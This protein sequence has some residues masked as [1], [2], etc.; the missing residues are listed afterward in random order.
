MTQEFKI[1][2]QPLFKVAW[3][4]S[5]VMLILIPIQ[6]LIF[7]I[8]PPP[9]TVIGLFELYHQSPFLGL[10]S[11]DFLYLINNIIL[12]VIFLTLFILLY[13]EKPTN[14][15]LALTFGLIGIACY[16]PSNP[17]FEM[18]TLSKLYFQ[19]QP[20]EVIRYLS[21]GEAL[22]AGYTGTAFDVYYVLSGMAIILFTYSLFKS[23][24]FR[25]SIGVWGLISG[26]FMII[27]SSAGL[28]GMIF[29]LLSLIPWTVFIILI[30]RK[31]R[32]LALSHTESR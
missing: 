22:M 13:H 27:P 1:K 19:A 23:P 14:S 20:E 17:A 29:A 11:L 3:Y 12:I 9:D 15:I 28:L 30:M 4:L 21:A 25:K 7:I 26:L 32:E 6:I 24:N 18:L 10:L 8:T 16:Y 5:I 2:F 31:F